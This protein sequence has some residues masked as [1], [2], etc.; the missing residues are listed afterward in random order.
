MRKKAREKMGSAFDIKAFH[1]CALLASRSVFTSSCD[2]HVSSMRFVC[3]LV[4]EGGA[5][6][7]HVLGKIV[8][9]WA[10]Q[11]AMIF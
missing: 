2:N 3:R 9:E 8:D 11:P 10:E 6:P 1:K 5:L 4:L 7:L